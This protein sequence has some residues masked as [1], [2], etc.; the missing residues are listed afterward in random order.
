MTEFGF[1]RGLA[2]FMVSALLAV[3]TV[4]C[5]VFV[6]FGLKDTTQEL[7][8][9]RI[10]GGFDGNALYLM[11]P[12]YEGNNPAYRY[13]IKFY[14]NDRCTGTYYAADT[15]NYEVEGT[16]SLPK[17]DVL[18]IDLDQYVDGDFLMTKLEKDVFYLSSD[19]NYINIIQPDT[20]QLRMYI[21]RHH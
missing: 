8:D 19:E 10:P 16:W 15:V 13:M 3:S 4:S 12:G 20:I 17:H 21:R 6:E 7:Y 18:R 5:E 1:N 14:D 9:A 2:V 11:M